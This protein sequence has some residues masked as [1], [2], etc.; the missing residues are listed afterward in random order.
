MIR[1]AYEARSQT[2]RKTHYH[3]LEPERLYLGEDE[4]SERL[5]TRPNRRF[6]AF[7]EAEGDL[8]VDMG[9]RAGRNFAPE[10]QRDSV[11]LFEA[12]ADHA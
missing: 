2:D 1:D 10:R 7:Q 3:P 11:N 8:V 12:T 5:K 6:S 4:W 9:A